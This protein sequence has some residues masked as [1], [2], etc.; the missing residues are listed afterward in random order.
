M[1]LVP[2]CLLIASLWPGMS[3]P[4]RAAQPEAGALMLKDVV[5]SVRNQY[6]PQLAALIE[7]DIA[8]G[9]VRS[10]QGAFEPQRGKHL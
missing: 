7:Q 5:E 4:S 10:A 1:K 3:T 6:P 8:N 9:R 2:I